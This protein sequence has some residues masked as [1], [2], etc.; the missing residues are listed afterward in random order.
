MQFGLLRMHNDMARC[1]LLCCKYYRESLH[2]CCCSQSLIYTF[3]ERCNLL[4]CNIF[5][6]AI[7]PHKTCNCDPQSPRQTHA[8]RWWLLDGVLQKSKATTAAIIYNNNL[9]LNCDGMNKRGSAVVVS[10]ARV[11]LIISAKTLK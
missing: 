9:F 6:F 11:V 1:Y 8:L 2:Y 7:F 3:K 4:H 10:R 5:T